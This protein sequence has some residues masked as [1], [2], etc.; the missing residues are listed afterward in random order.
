MAK[1][2]DSGKDPYAYPDCDVL[3]NRFGIKDQGQLDTLESSFAAIRAAELEVDPVAGSFDFNHLR[4]THRRLFADVYDW[5][6]QLRQ[7]DISKG[8]TRF[9]NAGYL[10]SAGQKLFLQLA[11]EKQLR[12][13]PPDELSQRLGEYLGEI[14]VLHPFREGNGRTQREFIGQL[15]RENGYRVNWDG[16]SQNDMV[17][18]SIEAYHGSSE[19]L[20]KL[21]RANLTDLDVENAV[22]D[23]DFAEP[24]L[25]QQLKSQAA[26]LNVEVE[27]SLEDQLGAQ[28]ISVNSKNKGYLEEDADEQGM[29][30]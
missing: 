28:E 14:N 22:R 29:D 17:N 21:I 18:A 5:A 10:E 24:S 6:G 9:A 27:P 16:I 1:Y 7:V 2:S 13:L 4:E 11:E 12:G 8:D 20:G 3:R 25:S 26:V 15:A 19:N 30:M 23:S